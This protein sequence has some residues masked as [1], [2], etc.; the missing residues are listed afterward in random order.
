[1]YAALVGGLS[2]VTFFFFLFLFIFIIFL[3]FVGNQ[4]FFKQTI[5]K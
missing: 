5:L 3:N 2:R 1:M 4:T